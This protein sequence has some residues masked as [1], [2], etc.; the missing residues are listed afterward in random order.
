MVPMNTSDNEIRYIGL[1]PHILD[2]TRLMSPVKADRINGTPVS[3]A[4][5]MYDTRCPLA[6]SAF[7]LMKAVF[8]T[9]FKA[10]T[11][12]RAKKLDSLRQRGQF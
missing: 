6:A 5:A 2:V 8:M 7:T 4:A 12:S 11:S 9:P 1:F 10:T 3:A